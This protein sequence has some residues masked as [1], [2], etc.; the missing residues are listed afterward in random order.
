MMKVEI[1]DGNNMFHRFM[2]NDVSGM[3]LRTMISTLALAA[4]R[5]RVFVVWDGKGALKYVPAP[6]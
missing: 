5:R 6:S 3:P 2:A 1:Y 4:Q